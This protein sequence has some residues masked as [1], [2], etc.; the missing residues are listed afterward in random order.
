MEASS[1]EQQVADL[2]RAAEQLEAEKETL[3]K[4]SEEAKQQPIT[5][6]TKEQFEVIY[7][8][9]KGQQIN[10]NTSYGLTLNM[11]DAKNRL[12]VRSLARLRIPQISYIDINHIEP[13]DGDVK[14]FLANSVPDQLNYLDFNPTKSHQLEGARFVDGLVSA[15][16]K[17]K[18]YFRVFNTDFD[19][20]SF[21]RVLAAAKHCTGNV[22]FQNSTIRSDS[23]LDFGDTLD[24]WENPSLYLRQ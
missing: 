21:A 3:L 19:G 15:A 20:E 6:L 18:T 7:L 12:L 5:Q 24:G 14:G 22:Y 4:L 17:C 1:L 23:Q 16:A 11:N 10:A 2:K 13:D 8:A 9:C